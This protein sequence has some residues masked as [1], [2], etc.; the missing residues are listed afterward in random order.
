M[1]VLVANLGSTSFKYRLYDMHTERQLARGG[2]DRIGED[3]DSNCF[4]EIGDGDRQEKQA[5]IGDHAA[6]VQMCLDQ[7]TNKETGCLSSVEEVA[8]IGFKAVFAG[9]LSGV[10][11]VDDELLDAMEALADVAPAH[12]PPYAK[13]MRQLRAAFPSI[14][15]VAAL[16]TAFHETIPP[17]Y[18]TYAVPHEWQENYEVRRWGFHGASHRYIGT[19]MAELLGR[20]D[21]KVI[22]CHL[23]GSSSVCAMQGGESRS[24]SMGM[25]PQSGLPQNNRVG[26]FDP[27]ALRLVKRLTGKDYDQLLDELASQGG[28]LGMSGVSNDARDIEQA[29]EKGN[30]QA[31][32]ALR[33]FTAEIK[34][35]VGAYLAVLNG[36]DAIV[37]TG[38]IGENS[39]RVRRD[40]CAGMD[41]VGLTLDESS[42]QSPA[43]SVPLLD[44]ERRIS[45]EQCRI[46]VWVVPT[47]EEI[48]VARQTVAAVSS[49]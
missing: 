17:E 48:V 16:E 10:R 12:N 44:G 23:G 34:R 40:V 21:L 25:T 14:P 4:V 37:F 38:G 43:S 29:A 2:I 6:A 11:V 18:R 26:D 36:A 20:D 5:R 24:T 30:Q 13:A 39:Q 31:D 7:L 3:V 9:K 46:Q 47:N 8:A 35:Y 27:F 19:R 49:S 42:V 45:A 41:Y 32:M 22:S 28:L 1:K 15:L 33:V